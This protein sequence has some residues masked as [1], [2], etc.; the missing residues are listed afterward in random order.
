MSSHLQNSCSRNS[1]QSANLNERGQPELS[2][3]WRAAGVMSLRGFQ[4]FHFTQKRGRDNLSFFPPALTFST[5][6]S[7]DG[8]ADEGG[9]DC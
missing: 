4:L 6:T 2:F 8:G 5:L 3:G 1:I 9:G 7:F